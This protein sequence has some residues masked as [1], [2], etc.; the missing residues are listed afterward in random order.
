MTKAI[1]AFIGL[2]FVYPVVMYWVVDRFGFVAWFVVIPVSIMVAL[3]VILGIWS[4]IHG[5]RTAGSA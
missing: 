5:K 4:H 3:W 1:L 2:F